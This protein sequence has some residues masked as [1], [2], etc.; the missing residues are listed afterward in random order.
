MLAEMPAP[1]RSAAVITID[2]ED[3]TFV[4]V[5][6]PIVFA[7]VNN[8]KLALLGGRS[9]LGSKKSTIEM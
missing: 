7:P 5:L 1:R 9:G 8:E 3:E 6:A 2:P 4:P